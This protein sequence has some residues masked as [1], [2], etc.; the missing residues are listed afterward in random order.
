MLT[1]PFFYA[2]VI[3]FGLILGSATVIYL[4]G[5]WTCY[6]FALLSVVERFQ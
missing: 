3:G 5:F 2:L 6:L 1:D 4:A